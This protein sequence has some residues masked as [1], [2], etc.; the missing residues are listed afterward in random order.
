[1]S[2]HEYSFKFKKLTKSVPSFVTD[3]RD[4]MS[5][6]VMG[7]SDD[8]KV[9]CHSAMLHDNMNISCLMVH[10][11]HV[12]EA[13]AKRK[14]RDVNNERYIY[15]GSSK[16]RLEIQDKPRF[17]KR[18]SSQVASNFLKDSGD[19]VKCTN[20]PTDKPTCRKYGKKHLVIALSDKIFF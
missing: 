16:S 17:K 9:E 12:E 4:E 3:P 13:R 6:F 18:V 1:M 5:R 2:V 10:A 19:R 7:V 20:S 15:G 8:L 14:S 11:K